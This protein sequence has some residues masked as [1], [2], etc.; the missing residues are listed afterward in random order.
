MN[1]DK[2]GLLEAIEDADF[3]VVEAVRGRGL[4]ELITIKDT[5][6][7]RQIQIEVWPASTTK[8]DL[9]FLLTR[10]A[11]ET[12]ATEGAYPGTSQDWLM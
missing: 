5:R 11:F 9:T 10:A 2:A 7:D 3:E 4:S 6:T 1:L 8:A 12:R